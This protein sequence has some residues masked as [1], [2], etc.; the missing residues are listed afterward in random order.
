[1]EREE[2]EL[3]GIVSGEVGIVKKTSTN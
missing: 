3:I 2:D 1:M